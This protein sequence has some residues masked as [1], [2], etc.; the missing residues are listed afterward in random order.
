MDLFPSSGEGLGDAHYVGSFRKINLHPTPSPEV[1]NRSIFRNI[2][3]FNVVY[4]TGRWTK[5]ENPEENS[6]AINSDQ[7]LLIL[8]WHTT[9]RGLL[10]ISY[11]SLAIVSEILLKCN[12]SCQL[13]VMLNTC[14]LEMMS[15]ET[16]VVGKDRTSD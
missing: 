12:V 1:G 10:H 5:Y 7:A 6:N 16:E 9:H 14:H 2:V 8:R 4:N 3:L 15:S 13:F 11:I